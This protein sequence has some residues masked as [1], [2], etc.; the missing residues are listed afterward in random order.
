MVCLG[1]ELGAA[2]LIKLKR[3]IILLKTINRWAGAMV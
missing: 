3:L 1:L 2:G